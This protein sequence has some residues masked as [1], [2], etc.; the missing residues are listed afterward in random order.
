MRAIIHRDSV[1]HIFFLSMCHLLVLEGS[2][3][4][5]CVNVTN[6][7]RHISI[8]WKPDGEIEDKE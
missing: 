1:T 5:R 3:Y 7:S 2:G 8:P 6:I 4:C